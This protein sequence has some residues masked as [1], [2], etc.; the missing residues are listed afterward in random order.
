MTHVLPRWLVLL[1]EWQVLI[2]TDCQQEIA[3]TNLGNHLSQAPQGLDA[4]LRHDVMAYV[5]MLQVPAP[6]QVRQPP[7]SWPPVAHLQVHHGFVCT[8]LDCQHT[9]Y[10][11]KSK[12]TAQRHQRNFHTPNVDNFRACHYQT[13]FLC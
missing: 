7:D 8:W 5:K 12:H 11:S 3:R 6:N 4:T 9:Y 2:S 1:K 10:I 13:F